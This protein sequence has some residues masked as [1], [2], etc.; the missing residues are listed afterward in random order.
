MQ[1]HVVR[2]DGRQQNPKVSVVERCPR[3]KKVID[4]EL[5][6]ALGAEVPGQMNE[7]IEE[8]G[9]WNGSPAHFFKVR[10]SGRWAMA[11]FVPKT[12][13]WCLVSLVKLHGL[14]VRGQAE[15]RSGVE[16]LRL[17]R[18]GL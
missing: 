1:K 2:K 14:G 10:L 16:W 11:K 12:V 3:N 15:W 8:V 18:L 17:K 7:D 6:L 9:N 5:E 13:T 4:H